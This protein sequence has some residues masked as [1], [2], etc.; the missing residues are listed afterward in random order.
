MRLFNYE[1]RKVPDLKASIL[2]T[3]EENAKAGLIKAR[4]ELRHHTFLLEQLPLLETDEAERER[5]LTKEA[6]ERDKKSINNWETQLKA[7]NYER[8]I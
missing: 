4:L 5:R 2:E 8:D 6:I 3:A 1:I 7:I